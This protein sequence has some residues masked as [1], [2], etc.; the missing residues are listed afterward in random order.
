MVFPHF[1]HHL[2]SPVAR[3]PRPP[4]RR[5]HP[6]IMKRALVTANTT[7]SL[8]HLLPKEL[9]SQVPLA[10]CCVKCVP[11]SVGGGSGPGP[12][13]PTA[14]GLPTGATAA[15]PIPGRQARAKLATG[16]YQPPPA[17]GGALQQH[18]AS[19]YAA[20]FW[21]VAHWRCGQAGGSFVVAVAGEAATTA[22]VCRREMRLFL[23]MARPSPRPG[24]RE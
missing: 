11:L 8:F 18:A 17:V 10:V 16:L 9:L 20:R 14:V 3:F 13:A 1:H 7:S 19:V 6:A 23:S 2:P 4:R 12:R 15:R 22:S 21:L 24:H 5:R